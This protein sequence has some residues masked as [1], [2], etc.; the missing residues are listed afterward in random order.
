LCLIFW[1]LSTPRKEAKR[2]LSP[3]IQKRGKK[4]LEIRGLGFSSVGEG[5]GRCP[6]VGIGVN[7]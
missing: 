5:L 4:G 2:R 6:K 1:S 7:R 3:K